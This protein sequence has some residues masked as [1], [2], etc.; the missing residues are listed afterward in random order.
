[1]ERWPK[2]ECCL[3]L[4]V[5]SLAKG[6]QTKGATKPKTAERMTEDDP[7][8]QYDQFASKY[9][10]IFAER[11]QKKVNALRP[12]V[13]AAPT[14]LALDV[15]AGTGI[16]S[17]M[18]ERTFISSDISRAMLTQAKGSRVQCNLLSL[19]FADSIFSLV[20]SVSVVR[21]I[22]PMEA[23]LR[24]LYRVLAN[25]GHLVLSILKTEDLA[26]AEYILSALCGR[27]P[28]RVDLGPD[29]GFIIEKQVGPL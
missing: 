27:P 6:H 5:G 8:R 15:G 14:G 7:Q 26:A 18:L 24:E 3:R 28:V 17:R 4:K 29:L 20:F 21:D 13:M 23:A 25:G 9:D 22:T 1:V 2:K 10:L 16:A 11:Q 19:P 12:A